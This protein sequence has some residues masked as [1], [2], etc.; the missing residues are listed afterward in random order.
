MFAWH[1]K[2]YVG[3]AH[4]LAG[5]LSLLLQSRQFLTRQELEQLVR[6]SIDFVAGLA[7]PSGN[8]PSS[9]TNNTDRSGELSRE[10]SDN[11]SRMIPPG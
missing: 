2:E 6:P 9:L 7:F 10:N 4:G 3:A 11:N 8:F 5:I 1:D